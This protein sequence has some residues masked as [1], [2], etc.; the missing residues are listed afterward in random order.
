MAL[1]S[2]SSQ[3]PRSLLG[4]PGT[5]TVVLCTK[6][7]EKKLLADYE[8]HLHTGKCKCSSNYFLSS[9]SDHKG[10]LSSNTKK[11]LRNPIIFIHPLDDNSTTEYDTVSNV[12][13]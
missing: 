11:T 1:V 8:S 6:H 5:T 3:F 7:E 4:T 12:F 10:S 2:Q 13:E 9:I